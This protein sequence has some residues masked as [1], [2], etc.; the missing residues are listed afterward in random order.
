MKKLAT[1]ILA[2]GLAVGAAA[3][4]ADAGD[5]KLFGGMS[6]FF[7]A[8]H[9]F[10]TDKYQPLTFG[11]AIN[12]GFQYIASENLS[13]TVMLAAGG[14]DGHVYYAEWGLGPKM[15][16]GR[17]GTAF[18]VKHA[19]L[20]WVVPSTKVKVRMG[21][22]TWLT[23]HWCNGPMGHAAQEVAGV[24]VNIPL[25][26]QFQLNLG[27]FRGAT[28]Q[29]IPVMFGTAQG[30]AY[31]GYNGR[32][33]FYVGGT[34]LG[35]GYIIQPWAMYDRESSHNYGIDNAKDVYN[36][37]PAAEMWMVGIGGQISRF[38]PFVIEFNA[39]YGRQSNPGKIWWGNMNS[40]AYPQ[41]FISNRSGKGF[42]LKANVG[43]KTKWG[44][45]T[46]DA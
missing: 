32:D 25:S 14:G 9:S 17:D 23:P 27:W 12:M 37:Q 18:S 24:T 45:P 19:Y 38:D 22:M 16:S 46:F 30:T 13:G 10:L 20:D 43:Y 4:S 5:V 8:D 41:L 6:H 29:V 2:A 35:Q 39:A 21:L 33:Y 15:M 36:P 44:T 7:M 1:L 26:Q 31:Y 42:G 28:D 11:S 3:P 34:L 40:N